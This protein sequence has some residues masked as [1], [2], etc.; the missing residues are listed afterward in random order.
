[1]KIRNSIDANLLETQNL[2]SLRF[3][4][5]LDIHEWEI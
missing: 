5:M 1:M 2:V 4:K 3:N